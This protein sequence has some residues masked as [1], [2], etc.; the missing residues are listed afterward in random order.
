MATFLLEVGTEELPAAFVSDAIAQWQSRIEPSLAEQFLTPESVEIYGTPRRLVALIK[1]LPTT[2]PDREEDAKGPPAQAAFKDGKPTKAAEGFAR[3]RGAAVEDLEIRSTDKGDFVFVT[4]KITGRRTA[5]ILIELVPD[6]ILRLDG[7]RL[8]RWGDGDIR[9]SRPVRWLVALMD[10]AVL[11]IVIENGSERVTSDCI[12]HGHRVL[13]PEPIRIPAADQY[14]ET[15]HSAYV[16]VDPSRRRETIRQQTAA[17]AKE[18]NGVASISPSLLEEVTQL[19][20]WPTAIAGQFSEAFLELPSEVAITEMESH[21]R[22]FPVLKQADSSELL[23][24]F[25]TVSNGDPAKSE[26]ISRGNE[27]VIQARLSDGKFFF[28]ADRKQPLEHYVSQLETVTFQED[29]GS[30]LAKVER[31][32]AVTE[33]IAHQL[34]QS[35]NLSAQER[36]DILRAAHLC[37]ADL[38]TQMVGEFPELQGVMGEKYAR[39][40]GEP[41]A[42]A[43]A[44]FEHY[45]PRGAG[46]KLPDTLAGQ[47]VGIA[48]RLD[49]LV[50]IFSLGQ[51]PSGSSDPFALRRAATAIVN[52][53]WHA[54]LPVNLDELLAQVIADFKAQVSGGTEPETLRSQLQSFFLQRIQTLLQDERGVDYDLVNAVLGE[55]DPEYTERALI[56]LLDVRNRALFLQDIRTNGLLAVIYETVNRASKLAL[57]GDLDTQTLDPAAVVDSTQFQQPTEQA[58]YDIL[59]KLVPETQAAQAERDYHRLVEGLKQAAPI[60]SEFFDGEQSVLVMADDPAIRQ[61]RL[62]L[63]GLLRNHARVLADFGAIVKQ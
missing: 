38:V 62:N 17:V 10:D 23:P 33:R 48:D 22:Y 47:V 41:E 54:D 32:E 7:K 37:K 44:I 24:Y 45:L 18:L 39:H 49:S 13:H 14:V 21:Q 36:A 51:I 29:L 9:F 11:P 5:D 30:M 8:M 50:S 43:M 3:S 2:Q 25:I 42:V 15:L 31:I 1:G 60:V 16:E 53:V 34:Q 52:I 26:I 56:D 20:E 57:K 27:R 4:Q 35:S 12:S 40:S 59:V 61:N 6:W 46:D 19:V 28:D 63:L 58:F 55:N